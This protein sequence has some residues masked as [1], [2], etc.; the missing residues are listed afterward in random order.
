[1]NPTQALR[2]DSCHH[3][4]SL[5]SC[6]NISNKAD[7]TFRYGCETNVTNSTPESRSCECLLRPGIA[8]HVAPPIKQF[9]QTAPIELSR[10]TYDRCETIQSDP[11]ASPPRV[12]LQLSNHT[13]AGPGRIELGLIYTP[14]RLSS[15]N[16]SGVAFLQISAARSR[17][18]ERDARLDDLTF[19]NNPIPLPSQLG[20]MHRWVQDPE[21][22]MRTSETRT[23][24]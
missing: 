16:S 9:F 20:P 5:Q 2:S 11:C 4:A 22:K 8:P 12:E 14:S 6:S 18:Q 23:M 3:A 15:A 10:R 19:Y 17:L 21:K 7:Q 1:M 13:N 24:D